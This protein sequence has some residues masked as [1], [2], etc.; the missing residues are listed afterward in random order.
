MQELRESN[1]LLG[2]PG[3]LRDRL[4]TDGYV[5]LRDVVDH[6]VL[7]HVRAGMTAW[8]ASQGLVELVD[9]APVLTGRDFATVGQHPQALHETGVCDWLS[10]RPEMRWVYEEVFGEPGYVLPLSEY[11]FQ[12]PST[13][14]SGPI[15]GYG[16]YQNRGFTPGLDFAVFWV[17][18][19]DMPEPVGGLAIVPDVHREVALRRPVPDA[20]V[21]SSIPAETF[22]ENAWFAAGYRPGDLLAITRFTPHRE[23]PN[24]SE[25]LRLSVEIRV[26]PWSSPRP[27]IGVV[28]EADTDSITIVTAAGGRQ[29]IRINE[30]TALCANHSAGLVPPGAYLGRRVVA[31][32]DGDTALALRYPRG[33]VPWYQ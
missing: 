22:A 30:H 14:A 1:D 26:Q 6:G 7:E 25:Q 4:D 17:P 3:A 28:T 9:G 15:R 27:V 29:V 24:R 2:R 11:Q 32:T 21:E 18:L 5:F 8:L 33:Y 23:L 12:A 31:V 19:V 16:I 10:M 20:Q 13:P